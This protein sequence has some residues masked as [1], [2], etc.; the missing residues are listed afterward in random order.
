MV[1]LG[2]SLAPARLVS[3]VANCNSVGQQVDTTLVQPGA[4][5]AQQQGQSSNPSNNPTQQAV[6]ENN[7]NDAQTKRP[8]S[9]ESNKQE[10]INRANVPRNR[11]QKETQVIK[12]QVADLN[13][14][15]ANMVGNG[16]GWF[17]RPNSK[18]LPNKSTTVRLSPMS[19]FWLAP[20]DQEERLVIARLVEIGDKQRCQGIVLDWRRLQ[21]VLAEEAR[22]TFPEARFEPMREPEPP[23]PERTMRWLPVELDP[24]PAEPPPM[25]VWTPLRSGLAIAWFAALVALAA[26]GLGGWSLIDLSERRIR[27]VSAVTHEL[28]TPL[29]TLR[30]YLDMLTGGLVQ[31][32]RQ[33]TEY[34]ATLHTET[35][36]LNRLV[37]NVLD[38]SRL[39]DQRPR[40]EK[41]PVKVAELLEQVRGDWQGR[42][43][44]A[45]KEL[46]V[47]NALDAG[48][49]IVTD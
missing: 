48:D 18:P 39:E 19:P 12:P 10:S 26:V 38:F 3:C 40:L 17:R 4:N 49:E 25:P 45:E 42:C 37:A 35:E 43:Q 31:E 32:E 5:P 21:E 47:E 14:A 28:R 44:G 9:N 23:N 30:L 36:R 1:D 24:G 7:A 29:T 8:Y 11:T 22:E 27:F 15:M 20:S 6:N 16:E 34:L 13:W 41:A 46:V 2:R 33:K